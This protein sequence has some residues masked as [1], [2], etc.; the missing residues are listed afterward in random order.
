MLTVGFPLFAAGVVAV[1]P[2]PAPCASAEHRAFD[3]WIGEWEVSKPDGTPAGRSRIERIE[4]GCG[5]LERWTGAGGITGTSLNAWDAVAGRWRQWWTGSDGTTLLL[6]GGLRDGAMVLEGPAPAGAGTTA[7]RNRITWTPAT[8]G[9][10]RQLWEV[11]GA[12]GAW[13]TAFD[14]IYRRSR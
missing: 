1:S 3:F 14:G 6:E 7:A 13:Q 2:A 5:I 10:V 4:A 12:D 11:L 9:S 8:D